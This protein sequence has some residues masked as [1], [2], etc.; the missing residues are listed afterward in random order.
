MSDDIGACPALPEKCV[1]RFFYMEKKF[2]QENEPSETHKNY[3]H[4]TKMHF[5][6]KLLVFPLKEFS[7]LVNAIKHIVI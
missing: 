5:Q 2:N 1:V 6:S 3:K 7:F 4:N